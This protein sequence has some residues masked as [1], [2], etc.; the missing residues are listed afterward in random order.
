[1]QISVRE[2]WTLTK[3]N[4]IL[5]QMQLFSF[6]VFVLL[7]Y[8]LAKIPILVCVTCLCAERTKSAF[9]HNKAKA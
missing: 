8:L 6:V 1:M 3:Y 9:F 7:F 2:T 4:N 5:Y